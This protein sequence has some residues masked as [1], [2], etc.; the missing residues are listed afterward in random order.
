M[1]KIANKI[2]EY[3]ATNKG[4]YFVEKIFI[5][6]RIIE[7]GYHNRNPNMKVNGE[8]RLLFQLSKLK[9]NFNVVFDVGA[10]VGEYS[11]F[12]KNIL[13]PEK[14]FAFEPVPKIYDLLEINC[15]SYKNIFIKNIALNDNDKPIKFH[16][17]PSAS[18]L[19][20]SVVSVFK[21][22]VEE[23][24][25]SSVRGDDFCKLNMIEK[26]DFLKID[27]EGNDFN[28]LKGFD[29]ILSKG[30]IRII[31][32]EYGPFS[33][34]SKNLLK[35]HFDLLVSKGYIIGKIYPKHVH[36]MDYSSNNENF[37]LS[38]FVAIRKEDNELFQLLK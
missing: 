27:T 19:S 9:S 36:F 26:I 3:L 5:L 7:L 34:Y 21:K 33:I 20:S 1:K 10:N 35:D 4:S 2:Q 29:Q 31:Q 38:N 30:S 24:F 23:I 17:S 16:Y 28:V 18:Y 11:L 22:D 15:Q 13:N 25:V 32:F 6:S 12:L 37:I 8:T 14:I